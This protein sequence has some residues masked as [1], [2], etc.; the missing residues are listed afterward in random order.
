MGYSFGPLGAILGKYANLAEG[1]TTPSLDLD[2]ERVLEMAPQTALEIG[3][4]DAFRSPRTPP[5]RTIVGRLYG[6]A[7][8]NV[9][10]ELLRTIVAVIPHVGNIPVYGTPVEIVL[11]FVSAAES[12]DASIVEKVSAYCADHRNMLIHLDTDSRRVLLTTLA[13]GETR[14]A[15]AAA[16]P[17][18]REQEANGGEAREPSRKIVVTG[19]LP[20]GEPVPIF[21][22]EE[23]YVLRFRVS[24]KSE[25]NLA[26]GDVDVTDVPESGLQARWVVA[27]ST[28]Q[29]LGVTHGGTILKRGD[30][31]VAQFDLPIP[32]QGDS[33]TVALAICTTSAPGE[34]ALTLFVGG[35]EYRKLLVKLDR[36]AEVADDIVCTVPAHLN[37]RTTHE[38]TTPP[39]H[40][41]MSVVGQAASIIT[42]SGP[43]DYGTVEW[44][45][46]KTS[47]NN[48][49]QNV[50]KALEDFRVK[51]E[52]HLE[53]VDMADMENRLQ[54]GQWKTYNWSPLL[55]YAD[56]AHNQAMEALRTTSQMRALANEGYALFNA[57]FPHGS[58]LRTIIERL[59][60]GSR[61]ELL[62]TGQGNPEWVSHVPWAL[63]Y[64]NPVKSTEPVDC[65]R[66]LG[67][68]FRIG[69]KAWES[70]AAPTSA[71]G[72]PAAVNSLNFLY[73]G[74][75]PKD[76]VGVQSS[77]QRAAFAKWPHQVFVP[78]LGAT[79]PKQQVVTALETPVP[80]PV[81]ILYFY[82]HCSVKDGSDPVLQFGETSKTPDIVGVSDI[83]QGRLESGPLVFAN[84]CTTSASHPQGTSEL[85][86]R[87]FSRGIRAFVGA[88]TKV[89]VRLASRFA[90]LFFQFFLRKVDHDPMAAGEALTQARLFLWTQFCNPGGLFYCF[91]NRYDLYLASKVEVENLRRK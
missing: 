64:L 14:S 17:K 21:L 91:V 16:S 26:R 63:M 42:V 1:T 79:N 12:Q 45:A 89:P 61:I 73:W 38:W 31:W 50:R 56:P 29:I 32:G 35:G 27:S 41:V 15:G 74:S 18:D 37:L 66:F 19:H 54:S 60:P 3:L 53:N 4:A 80:D 36:G 6:N 67:L 33:D 43:N 39:E 84:A 85:E 70:K 86:S 25:W 9:R 81:A 23:R 75:D 11:S 13:R 51:A 34:L 44:K 52:P 5:F 7:T 59:Q 24:G 71:L 40:I 90:W 88:E 55:R 65:E 83:Y 72:D 62:W 76:E 69:S 46:N 20:W 87:F 47:L 82:C 2:F 49:I 48:P 10:A 30:T 77:W 78:D 28:V 68:R 22:P 57:C 58:D 8:D